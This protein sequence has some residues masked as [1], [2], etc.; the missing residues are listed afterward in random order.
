MYYSS[1]W[2]NKSICSFYTLGIHTIPTEIDS[3]ES[4]LYYNRFKN[5]GEVGAFA[6]DDEQ[7]VGYGRL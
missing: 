4:R 6:A 7:S 3:I 2:C 1:D 5:D